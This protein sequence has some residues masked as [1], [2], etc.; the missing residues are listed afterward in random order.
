MN[1]GGGVLLDGQSG[2]LILGLFGGGVKN[3]QCFKSSLSLCLHLA[4]ISFLLFSVVVG[5]AREM[6]VFS[7]MQ[8]W[9]ALVF[10]LQEGA[11]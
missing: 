7:M 9:Q 10:L 5:S 6:W 4:V 11:S 3:H 1:G 8:R 2:V